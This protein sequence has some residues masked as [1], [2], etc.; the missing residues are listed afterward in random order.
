MWGRGW[1]LLQADLGCIEPA[2]DRLEPEEL[3][4]GDERQRDVV[5]PGSCLDLCIALHDLDHVA[6]MRLQDLV[7]V[8]PRN[9]EGHQHL[10]YELVTRGR[11][12]VGWRPKPVG[13]LARAGG[14]DPVALLRSLTL[15]IVCLDET[16][17]LEALERSCTPARR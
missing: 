6:T 14:S 15:S 16:V 9:L 17:A 3:G 11:H 13:Q 12:E 10:D 2:D 4:I 7:D 5:L 8:G 1:Q